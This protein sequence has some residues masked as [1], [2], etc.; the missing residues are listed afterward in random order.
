ML[1]WHHVIF[2]FRVDGLVVRRDIDLVVR[3]LIFAEIFEKICISSTV[4]VYV[5][6]I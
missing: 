3:Q 5:G 4:E 1:V 2:V 6:V